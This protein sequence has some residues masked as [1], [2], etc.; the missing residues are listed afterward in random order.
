M[1]THNPLKNSSNPMSRRQFCRT[2]AAAAAGLLAGFAAPGQA[3]KRWNV[4]LVTADDLGP[5]LG[6]YG[7]TN[8]ATPHLDRLAGEGCLFERAY[9]T[10]ASCSPSRSSIFTGLYPHQNG[11]LGLGHLGYSMRAGQ[12][13]I[14]TL[15][16]QNGYRTGVLGKVHVAPLSAFEWDLNNNMGILGTQDVR[17]LTDN[18]EEFVRAAGEEPFFLMVNY[19]DPHRPYPEGGQVE[20]V[21]AVPL[22]PHDVE[23]FPFLLVDSPAVRADTAGYYN[24]V[25]RID[26]G[27]GLLLDML[28]RTG[29]D[30]DTVVIFLGDHGPPFTRAKGTCYEAGIRIPFLVRWPGI[31]EAGARSGALVSTVDLMPTIFRA[32]GIDPPRSEGGDLRP[33]VAGE[34]PPWRASLCAEYN[35]HIPRLFYPQRCIRDNRFKLIHNLLAGTPNPVR[36]IDGCSAFQV[37]R[38]LATGGSLARE[39]MDRYA[40]PPEF[41]LYDLEND[42]WEFHNLAGK[43]KNADDLERLTRALRDWRV[44][45]DDPFLDADVLARWAEMHKG[46][47]GLEKW[48]GSAP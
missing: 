36:G 39:V 18:A 15:L 8:M 13:T 48:D 35:S 40:D 2:G 1:K 20:G 21:P 41:E 28:R 11:Q 34:H 46:L 10:Q 16:K 6:C 47:E 30:E 17:K 37:A 4:L 26:A 23:S 31:A 42:P 25:A 7:D 19:F 9:V 44:A 33:L 45:T 12:P 29:R 27:M 3:R 5:Q 24:A 38:G 14:P 22:E 43:K 32:A